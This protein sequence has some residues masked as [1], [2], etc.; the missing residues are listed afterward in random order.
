[1]SENPERGQTQSND[2]EINRAGLLTTEQK[3]V[4]LMLFQKP[5]PRKYE[6]VAW[7]QA[8]QLHSLLLLL[9]GNGRHHS[10]IHTIGL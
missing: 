8:A 3:L 9:W 10:L 6:Q 2:A 7:P 5:A 1:M 4:W